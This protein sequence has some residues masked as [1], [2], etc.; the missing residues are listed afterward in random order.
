MEV[1]KAVAQLWN[2]QIIAQTRWPNEATRLPEVTILSSGMSI[3]LYKFKI[4]Q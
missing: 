3:E 2:R 1:E 4:I